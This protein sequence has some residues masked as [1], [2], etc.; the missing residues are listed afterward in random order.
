MVERPFALGGLLA[1]ADVAPHDAGGKSH[2]PEGGREDH[3]TGGPRLQGL[4]ILDT[5]SLGAEVEDAH[6]SVLNPTPP[7]LRWNGDPRYFPALWRL[8]H[9]LFLSRAASSSDASK[10][11][12][13]FNVLG[14]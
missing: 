4:D 12:G 14:S 3:G 9:V 1:P 5:R 8:G 6:I 7:D 2:R 13:H 10:N 11:V